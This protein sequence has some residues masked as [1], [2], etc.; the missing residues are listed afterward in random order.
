MIQELNERSRQ[1]FRYIVESYLETGEP[2]GSRTLSQKLRYNLSPASIRNTMSDLEQAGLLFSPHTSAGRVPTEAG[3]RMFVDGLLEIGNLTPDERQSIAARVTESGRTVEDM[4]T[5]ATRMLSGLSHCA[6]L[7][8]APKQDKPLRHVE[9]V[10]LSDTRALVVIVTVDGTVENRVIELEPGMTPSTLRQATNYLNARVAGRTIAEARGQITAELER[11]RAELDLLSA[12]LVEAGLAVRGGDAMTLIISGQ[13]RLLEELSA[14]EDLE[15]VRRLFDDLEAKR[16]LAALL[17]RAQEA[18][19]V[20]IFIGSE[21][22]LFSLS[23]SSVIVAPF[24]TAQDQI[25]GVIGVIGPTR[26]NYGRVIPMVD[27]TAKVIG[28]LIG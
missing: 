7:V 14:V 5:E 25:L 19:G 3:L 2:I 13:A 26:V 15:R 6:G 4:L 8:L 28:R 12:R 27:Y 22:Q 18:E 24:G 20:R 1:I 11:N 21:N 17:D 23:G 16:D 9:F 10:G